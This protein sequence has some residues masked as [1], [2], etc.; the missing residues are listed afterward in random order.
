MSDE[1]MIALDEFAGDHETFRNAISELYDLTN[2]RLPFDG[3]LPDALQPRSQVE[4]RWLTAADPFAFVEVR[5]LAGGGMS[6]AVRGALSDSA[7]V[8]LRQLDP[9]NAAFVAAID[10]M[11]AESRAD[12]RGRFLGRSVKTLSAV[13]PNIYVYSTEPYGPPGGERDTFVVAS[14]QQP[15]ELRDKE[16]SAGHWDGVPFAWAE[17]SADGKLELFGHMEALLEL[18]D[19]LILEDDFAPVDNLLAPVFESQ[20]N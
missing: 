3:T 5:R 6:L 17:T 16:R 8:A 15:I 20:D 13:F 18:S 9:T 7:A 2:E 11:Y 10:Q 14:S 12:R 4:E 19:H 1:V